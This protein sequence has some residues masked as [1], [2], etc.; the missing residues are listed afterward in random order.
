MFAML[1]V[2][3]LTVYEHYRLDEATIAAMLSKHL[4]TETPLGPTYANSSHS[5]LRMQMTTNATIQPKLDNQPNFA[6]QKHSIQWFEP[7]AIVPVLCF[8]YQTHE[9]IVPVYACMK[10]RFIGSFMKASI[11]GLV[12]LFFLYNLVGAYGYLTFGE[13][14]GPDI[15][16][17]YDAQDP[18]VVV[19]IVALV[20]KFITTYPPLM[21]CGRSALDG[22]YGEIRKLS[23][24][25]FKSSEKTRRYVITTLWFF[26]TVA[27]AVF[28]PDISVTLQLLGSMASINVFVFPGM[29]LISLTMRLRRA[30]LALLMGEL[31]DGESSNCRQRAKDYYLISGSYFGAMKKNASARHNRFNNQQQNL[32]HH[33]TNGYNCCATANNSTKQQHFTA[34]FASLIEFENNALVGAEEGTCSGE[35]SNQQML[36]NGVGESS[37]FGKCQKLNGYGTSQLRHQLRQ[38]EFER[39]TNGSLCSSSQDHHLGSSFARPIND[40]LDDYSDCDVLQHKCTTG[41]HHHK[42]DIINSPIMVSNNHLYNSS[43]KADWCEPDTN[44][45]KDPL[46]DKSDGTATNDKAHYHLFSNQQQNQNQCLQNSWNNRSATGSLLDRLG[47]SIAPSTVAQIGISRCTA[48]GLYLFAAFLII[49]GAFIFVLELMNVFGFL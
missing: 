22:L 23:T 44:I 45:S 34:T 26:S 28:A 1:Y 18:I 9:V 16:T 36:L 21:F 37:M 31:P 27:L 25:E 20:V 7:L 15:M 2:A 43:S 32:N 10:Q 6:S 39:I 24:E 47:S 8:A 5:L 40:S 30:R 46:L 38:E 17:L 29:C 48:A 11:F 14:V 42:C 35:Q 13:N 4:T 41:H 33:L 49:F 19:G 3:F 12:I